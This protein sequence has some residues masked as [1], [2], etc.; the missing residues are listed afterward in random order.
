MF[1]ISEISP[2]FSGKINLAKRM[3]YLSFLN[4]ASA[5]K[6]QLYP[7]NMFSNDNLDRA[8]LE[9]NLIILKIF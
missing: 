8:Y 5:V 9:L 7:A 6:L 4:G 1:I 2:Q 3:I